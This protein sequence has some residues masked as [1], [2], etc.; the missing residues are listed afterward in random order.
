MI[1]ATSSGA[2]SN[3]PDN[4]IQKAPRLIEASSFPFGASDKL[5]EGGAWRLT[6]E[7][8]SIR[9]AQDMVLSSPSRGRPKGLER[10]G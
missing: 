6:S 4:V 7:I 5:K 10:T 2:K 8:Y 9:R 1:A 3:A